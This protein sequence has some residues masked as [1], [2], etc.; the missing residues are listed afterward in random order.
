[1]AKY[2][3][4]IEWIAEIDDTEF[5]EDPNSAMS[6]TATLVAD[7]WGKTDE[8]VRADLMAAKRRQAAKRSARRMAAQSYGRLP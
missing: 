3:S 5:L 6:V 1:M 8:Q 2:R 7:L 4:A